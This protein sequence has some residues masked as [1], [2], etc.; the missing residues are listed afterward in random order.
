MFDNV[1]RQA[2]L[3]PER[4]SAAPPTGAHASTTSSASP[5]N[6]DAL[7]LIHNILSYI[8]RPTSIPSL[9]I[10]DVQ[11]VATAIDNT[12]HTP[13]HQHTTLPSDS[14]P[15]RPTPT[16]IT[17]SLKHAEDV[18]GVENA[19]RYESQLREKGYGPDVLD[20]VDNSSLEALGISPGDCIRLKR[21]APVWYR[22]PEA[23]RLRTGQPSR[24][25]TADASAQVLDDIVGPSPLELDEQM[26]IRF[27]RRL[28]DGTGAKTYYG[29][30]MIRTRNPPVDID[31]IDHYFNEAA[32]QMFP[33][34]HGW[35]PV[36]AFEQPDSEEEL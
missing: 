20:A 27:E 15:V 6:A 19:Q 1:Y 18:L 11:P 5:I 31:Y 21:G 32:Q 16:K 33:V 36:E 3:H 22:S 35:I 23:K 26:K 29:P 14:S 28:K 24:L 17:C 12:P 13:P 10:S 7:T 4:K 25:T 2:A 8:P 30:K 9:Q 34:P